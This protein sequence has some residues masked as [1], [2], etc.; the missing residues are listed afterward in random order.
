MV[1]FDGINVEETRAAAH[2]VL[3]DYRRLR[4]V[5]R[6]E[7]Q[8]KLTVSYDSQ[9]VST[10][11]GTPAIEK[12]VVAKV[13]AEQETERIEAAIASL[14]SDKSIAI[15]KHFYLTGYEKTDTD[16]CEYLDYSTSTYFRYKAKGLLEIAWA[17]GCEEY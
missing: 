6:R 8:Q 12:K 13:Y 14:T 2:A 7:I 17:L 11:D 16:L 3:K 15:L 1:D 4:M 5:A 10:A 9:P